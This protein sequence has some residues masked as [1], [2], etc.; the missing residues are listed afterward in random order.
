MTTST[1]K[2]NWFA[3]SRLGQFMASTTGRLVRIGAGV[4]VVAAGLIVIGGLPGIVV[5]AIGLVP[6]LAGS[7][8]IC[9]LS[10]LFGGPLS[11]A[12]I[13]ACARR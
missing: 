4:A 1:A 6:M 2:P 9:I 12:E 8:D 3:A 5:A 10:R 13:R 7:I 11:G